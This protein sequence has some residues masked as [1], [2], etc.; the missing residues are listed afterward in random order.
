MSLQAEETECSAALLIDLNPVD[1]VRGKV[2]STEGG[3]FD[4]INDRPYVA[5]SFMSTALSKVFHSYEWT[6]QFASN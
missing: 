3:L 4:Y 2:G 6:L 5:S 1:L